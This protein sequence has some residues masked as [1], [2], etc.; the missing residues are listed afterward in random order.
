MWS[1]ATMSCDQS[2]I[3]HSRAAWAFFRVGR[4]FAGRPRLFRKRFNLEAALVDGRAY[5]C[6]TFCSVWKRNW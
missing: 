4:A 2:R 1:I 3:E 5:A 6:N